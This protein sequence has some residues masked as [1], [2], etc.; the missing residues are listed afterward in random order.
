MNKMA[1]IVLLGLNL[2]VSQAFAQMYEDEVVYDDGVEYVDEGEDVVADMD[3]DEDIAEAEDG[4]YNDN[5]GVYEPQPNTAMRSNESVDA[6][7]ITR[8]TDSEEDI[9]RRK[10]RAKR[11][12]QQEL[13]YKQNLTRQRSGAFIGLGTGYSSLAV[14]KIPGASEYLSLKGAGLGVLIGYQHALNMYSGFRIYAEGDVNFN[15]GVFWGKASGTAYSTDLAIKALGNVDFYLEGN[16]GRNYTETLGVF[17]GLGAGYIYEPSYKTNMAALTVNG[18][19]HSII[20]THN[21][22]ELFARIYP[23]YNVA[24][25]MDIWLR[26]SYMF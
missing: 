10:A 17:V 15:K 8:W 5:D 16:M 25:N 14:L 20:L 4:A 3:E 6:T 11:E 23:L 24:Q 13:E 1:L 22:I 12:A 26:Y 9:A 2:V 7:D 18:G 21:R 19:F